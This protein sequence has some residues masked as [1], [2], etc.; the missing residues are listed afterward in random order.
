MTNL[1]GK[2]QTELFPSQSK[3]ISDNVYLDRLVSF[4]MLWD[5]LRERLLDLRSRLQEKVKNDQAF[6][7]GAQGQQETRA[8]ILRQ[9][10]MAEPHIGKESQHKESWF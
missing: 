3:S 6:H 7:E 2:T 5:L 4:S 9:G 1:F 8:A 10:S